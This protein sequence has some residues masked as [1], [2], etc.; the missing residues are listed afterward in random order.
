M[1]KEFLSFALLKWLYLFLKYNLCERFI[2]ITI[3]TLNN[4]FW[5]KR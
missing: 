2:Q 5:I 3:Q 4:M 1:E